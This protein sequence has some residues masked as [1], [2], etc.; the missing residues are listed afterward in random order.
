MRFLL[1]ISTTDSFCFYNG[2][3]DM[4]IILIILASL[5]FWVLFWF[6][7]FGGINYLRQRSD[8]RKVEA[9]NALV[10]EAK[11][12]APLRSVDD[13]RDAAA[14]LMLLIARLDADPTREQIAAIENKLRTVFGFEQELAER[15]THARFIARQAESFDQAARVFADL[16]KRRLTDDER[17]ELV[18]MLQEISREDGPSES[19]TEA[20]AA[21]G[22]QIGL[23]A[24]RLIP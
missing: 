17:H 4:P 3:P 2:S 10:R 21:F 9:L 5:A 14:I 19:Q 6:I 20:I 13:P 15:M 18:A 11:R 24:A 23:A 7:R 22:P 1:S 12:N 16:F 8:Q